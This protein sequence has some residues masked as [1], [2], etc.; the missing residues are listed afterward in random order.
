MKSETAHGL[1]PIVKSPNH[2]FSLKEY[3]LERIEYHI[4]QLESCDESNL[5]FHQGAIK[6]LRR[7][8]T[9][10]DEVEETVKTIR[11]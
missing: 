2:Y 5:K 6:E 10:R 3:A 8:E 11:G 1:G 4:K 7:F 9:L